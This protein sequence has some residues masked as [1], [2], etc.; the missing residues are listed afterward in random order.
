[1]KKFLTILVMVFTLLLLTLTL[2]AQ[3]RFDR[4]P[5]IALTDRQHFFPMIAWK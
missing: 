5:R 1:M 4:S 2:N 3:D